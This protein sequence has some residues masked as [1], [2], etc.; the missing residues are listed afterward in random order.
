MSTETI[1]N[2]RETA[3]QRLRVQRKEQEAELLD[4]AK[5]RGYRWALDERTTFEELAAVA[6]L[7]GPY[8]I[9]ERAFAEAVGCVDAVEWALW[10]NP[11]EEQMRAFVAGALDVFFEAIEDDEEQ[12]A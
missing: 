8:E 12:P 2:Q 7:D 1:D 9:T 4:V 5:V 6:R 10:E 11:T 3:I